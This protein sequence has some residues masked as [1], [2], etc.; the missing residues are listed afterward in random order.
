M[1]GYLTL[2]ISFSLMAAS[3]GTA[4]VFVEL[5]QNVTMSRVDPGNS[6]EVTV[7]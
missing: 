4:W 6:A 5:S 1:R 2:L 3:A 7:P